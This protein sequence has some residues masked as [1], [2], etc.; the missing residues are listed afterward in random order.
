LAGVC[1]GVIG[2][3][4]ASAN[5]TV[6]ELNGGKASDAYYNL[7]VEGFQ[8][9]H[10]SLRKEVPPGLAQLADPYDPAANFR[11]RM[12]PTQADDLSYYRGKFYIYFGATPALLLLWPWAALTGHYLFH[13]AAVA[14]FCIAG[15]LA[16]VGLLRAVWR[17]YFPDV[18][19]GVAAA[20]VL[21]L[22][23]ATGA[24]ILLE[25]AD[26]WEVPIS[27][28]YALTFLTL[29][30]V[31]CAFHS[32]ARRG[33][34]LAAAGTA[35]GL[36]V[37][38]RP[39]VLF[40]AIILV[41]PILASR[42]EEGR[43]PDL[44]RLVLA[45]ILPLVVCGLGLM[46]YNYMRFDS[47]LE[48]GQHY[49]LATERQGEVRH[50]SP[51]Y[52]GFNFRIYFLEPV[53]WTRGFPFVQGI[54]VPPVPAGHGPVEDPFGVLS[55][56]PFVWLALAAPLA[57]RGRTAETAV[58]VRGFIA[59]AALL[60]AIPALTI[61]LFYGACS[62]YEMEF[63]PAL[64]LLAV[65]GVFAIERALARRPAWLLGARIGWS[66]LLAFSLAFNLLAGLERYAEERYDIGN[67]LLLSGRIPAAVGQFQAALRV[68]PRFPDANNNLGNALMRQGLLPEA[69]RHYEEALRQ[70]P[71]LP[72][73]HYNM[74]NVLARMDRRPEAVAQYEEALRLNPGYAEAHYNLGVVLS[75][76]G[77]LDEAEFHYRE[78][79]RL[80]PEMAGSR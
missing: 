53:R 76:L 31:W 75:Q 22:G 62:R 67:A 28:S 64:V 69:M 60:F 70:Q 5:P 23:L 11:Y 25:R 61:C 51:D 6:L 54:R 66:L 29:A 52:L 15:F 41:L 12:P 80:R 73:A 63:L 38:A 71:D 35:F 44:L 3:F 4:I 17:R 34:W 46:A 79:L 42:S 57:W 74:G 24:P 65:V 2:I 19:A 26:V 77:R 58:R 32:P 55:N 48:F 37:G 72:Q 14:L 8:D 7:L 36:A 47:P 10:V 49:Q 18:G 33:R 45:A 50:F 20:G 27:C 9:G 78:A 43:R 40:V 13:R 1:A 16:S 39:S 68:R 21:A 59:A 30:A 56:I